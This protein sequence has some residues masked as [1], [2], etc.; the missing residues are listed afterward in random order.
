[1]LFVGSRATHL[2]A[3]FFWFPLFRR[4]SAFPIQ[5]RHEGSGVLQSELPKASRTVAVV[6]VGPSGF[7]RPLYPVKRRAGTRFGRNI[8]MGKGHVASYVHFRRARSREP[9]A[10]R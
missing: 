8:D 9:R 10:Y 1:M 5:G 2:L 6:T 3:G 4:S 7:G